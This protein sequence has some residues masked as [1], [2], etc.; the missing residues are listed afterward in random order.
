MAPP[1]RNTPTRRNLRVD[2]EVKIGTEPAALTERLTPDLASRLARI[3]LAHVTREYPNKLDHVLRAP[4]DLLS[5]RALHPVFYGSFDWHSCVHGYWLLATLLRLFPKG[6]N[7][8]GKR[9]RMSEAAEI[10]ALFD[11]Q[12]TVAK[13]KSEVKYLAQPLRAT[14]ER[15]YG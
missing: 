13:V 2:S 4:A 14:F 10:E 7:G 3:A 8:P 1:V 12:L 15:P 11:S 6:E 9:D 5:P